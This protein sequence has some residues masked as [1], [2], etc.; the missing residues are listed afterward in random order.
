MDYIVLKIADKYAIKGE[1]T[2]DKHTD[3][4]NILGYSTGVAMPLHFDS[5]GGG[6]A[7]GRAQVQD[8][9]VSKYLDQATPKLNLACCLAT[10]LGKIYIYLI[11]TSG[12]KPIE[13]MTYTL[14]NAM[15]SSVSLN[16]GGNELPVESVTFN[17]TKITWSYQFET[18]E[19][20]QKGKVETE[21]DLEKATGQG[22]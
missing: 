21:Y 4:I 6:R 8:I 20:D 15:V 11:R 12:D 14:E 5:S 1:C 22:K 16:A 2:L 13:A 18:K 19:G 17:F 3:E 9:T 7:T 10:E